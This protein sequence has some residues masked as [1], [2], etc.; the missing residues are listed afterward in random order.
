M[1][2]TEAQKPHFRYDYWRRSWRGAAGQPLR[3]CIICFAPHVRKGIC[4][5]C[6]DARRAEIS[7]GKAV[8]LR[9]SGKPRAYPYLGEGKTKCVDCIERNREYP[10]AL[11]RSDIATE[12]DHRDWRE[13]LK[14]VPVCRAHNSHRGRAMTAYEASFLDLRS[15]RPYLPK[16]S[17]PRQICRTVSENTANRSQT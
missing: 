16:S 10:H 3:F 2:Q 8:W 15:P 11:H 14:V 1:M 5:I 9:E 13:P 17:I 12:W 4:N 7:K 6:R